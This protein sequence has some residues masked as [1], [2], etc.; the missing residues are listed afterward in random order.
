MTTIGTVIDRVFRQYLEPPSRQPATCYTSTALD[1]SQTDVT[2]VD[3]EVPEDEDLLRMGTTLE[4]GSEIVKVQTY[5]STSGATVIRREQLGTA[6]ATHASGTAVKLA[7]EYTRMDALSAAIENMMVLGAKLYTVRT[8]YLDFT[9]GAASIND[10]AVSVVRFRPDGQPNQDLGELVEIV[11]YHPAIG[12]RAAVMP[13]NAPGYLTYRCRLGVP[14]DET[15][16]LDSLGMEA[17]WVPALMVGIAADMMVG[18]DIPEAQYEWISQA[19]EAENVKY[20]S[21][22]Q[23]AGSLKGYQ[24]LL[25]SEY[26]TEMNREYRPTVRMLNPFAQGR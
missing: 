6:A 1:S 2:L 12:G 14:T 4:L 16:T 19:I 25:I 11:D 22:L 26:V 20:G 13:Y 7:P 24:R 17:V 5:T 9:D 8:D 18:R 23:L 3:F 15:T 10:L 21:R